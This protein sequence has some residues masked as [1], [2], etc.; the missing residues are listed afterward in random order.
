MIEIAE[1]T[2]YKAFGLTVSCELPLPELPQAGVEGGAADVVIKKS[3]LFALWSEKSVP[4][5]D[6][7]IQENLVM[8]HIPETAIFLI[9]NGNKILFSPME[10]AQEDEL[11]LYILGTCMG[12]V[13][14]H[15][16]ILPLHGSAIA[17]DGKVY[18]IVGESGAGKST[19]ASAFLKRGYQLLSDDVIPVAVT[20]ENVPV[21]IPAYPQQKLWIESLNE[22][23][24]ESSNYQPIID[25]ETKFAIPVQSQFAGEPLPLAGVFELV[26]TDQDEIELHSIQK[27]ERFYTLF[28]HTYR[29]FF[30]QKSGLMDWHFSTLAKIVNKI[31]LYQ[32]RRPTSR[33]TAHDLTDLILTTLNKGETV[34]D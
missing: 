4:N 7:I 26:K 12:T 16:K 25:R 11:R 32:L 14:L 20:D 33:F 2:A 24:M 31:E 34:N 15:R 8:F 6:F 19:L 17:I 23:E 1:K 21:V 27:L 18:A 28:T 13:L 29:N 5:E 30:V 3:D 22:F 10:G 9:E